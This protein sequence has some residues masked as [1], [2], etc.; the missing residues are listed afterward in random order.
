MENLKAG[1]VVAVR[2][3]EKSAA[4]RILG[5]GPEK[6]EWLCSRDNGVRRVAAGGE[7]IEG[8]VTQAYYRGSRK[9]LTVRTGR[10][11]EAYLALGRSR[12]AIRSMLRP[13][14]RCLCRMLHGG[15]RPVTGPEGAYLLE[16]LRSLVSRPPG[17]PPSPPPQLDWDV[18][19]ELALS[20]AAVGMVGDFWKALPE[21][22]G[23]P[24]RVRRAIDEMIM[25][26]ERT[27]RHALSL[28]GAGENILSAAGIPMLVLK[29]PALAWGTYSRAAERIYGDVDI[30]VPENCR[31]RAIAALKEKGFTAGAGAAGEGFIRKN[32]FHLVMKP[33]GGGAVPLE[34]HWRLVD[35]GNLY[36]IDGDALFG[37][38]R[39]VT[40]PGG[41]VRTLGPEDEFIYLCLHLCKHGVLNGLAVDKGLGEQWIVDADSGNRLLWFVDLLYCLRRRVDPVDRDGVSRRAGEWN[42]VEEVEQCLQLVKGLFP[43]DPGPGEKGE[44]TARRRGRSPGKLK[45]HFL[46]WA[47]R[48]LP[49][50]VVRPVRFLQLGELFFPAPARLAR[51]CGRPTGR[52][53]AGAYLRHPARMARRLF[54]GRE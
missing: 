32:H 29:G 2:L 28:I 12:P 9:D 36:S 43:D 19:L 13:I 17:K 38:A 8:L 21:K 52:G 3:G 27:S 40:V 4:L 11:L 37:R 39:S 42:A 48:P 5:Q 25:R 20:H 7:E 46:R 14:R 1:D 47:M 33:P 22:D 53:L 18:C 34:L 35:R 6:G 30:L 31:D 16:S 44:A 24:C 23:P 41:T 54:F 51:H 45:R 50:F 15:F 26:G 49:V 10:V